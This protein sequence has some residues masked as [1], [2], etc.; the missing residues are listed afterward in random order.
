MI[1]NAVANDTRVYSNMNLYAKYIERDPIVQSDM[2]SIMSVMDVA[3]NY[4]VTIL[5]SDSSMS[6]D[7]VKA[8]ITLEAITDEPSDFLGFS[9][10]G[11]GGRAAR[12]RSWS[13]RLPRPGPPRDPSGSRR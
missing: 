4:A 2:K 9:V 13:T 11:N 3:P 1:E 10:T 6:A 12:R 8:A 5:S 7:A